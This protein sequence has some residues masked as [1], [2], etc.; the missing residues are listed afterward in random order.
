MTVASWMLVRAP[1]RIE[2]RSPRTMQWN[3]MPVSAPTVT[4]PMTAAVGAMNASGAMVG[5]PPFR[6][7][8]G[9]YPPYGR[10]GMGHLARADAFVQ[11]QHEADVLDRGAGG[12]FAEIVPP[13]DQHDIGVLLVG[14]HL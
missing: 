6:E 5:E 11:A 12:A 10:S 3:Q 14:I 7:K 2:F 1:M 13:R 8:I 9:P 4:S